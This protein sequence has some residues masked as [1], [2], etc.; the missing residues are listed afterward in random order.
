VAVDASDNLYVS[1]YAD[2]RVLRYDT[3]L[4]TDTTA[5]AVL[6]QLD[7]THVAENLTDAQGL[8]S[9]ESVAIDKSVTPN[10][11]YVS[12]S[13]NNRVLGWADAASFSNAAPADLV[14]GQPDFLSYLCNGIN[15]TASASTLCDPEGVAVDGSGNLYIADT[16]NQRV[17]EYANP[18][19]AC[20]NNFP[21]VGGA[22]NLVLGQGNSF[23]SNTCDFDTGGGFTDP[24]SAIDLCYPTGV[25]V[26]G[27]GNLYV[28]DSSNSRVVEYN[29]PLST[30]AAAS[31]VFGQGGSFTSKACDFDAGSPFNPPSAVDL[32]YP[33]GVAVDGLGNLYVADINNQRVLEYNTPLNPSSGESSAGDATADTVFGQGGSFT[34]KKCNLGGRSANSL[35][36][37]TAVAADNAGNVYIEDGTNSRVLEYNTPLTSGT[38]AEQVFG[39][40]GSFTSSEC[41]GVSASSLTSPSG[42]AADAAGNLYVVDSGDN[43]VL[44]YDQ[45][46]AGPTPTVSPTPTFTPTSTGVV[47]PTA[48]ATPTTTPTAT[49]TNTSTATA[50]ATPTPTPIPVKLSI[51]P[52]AI[53]FG[54]KTAVGRTSKPRAVTIKNSSKKG[55]GLNVTV[56]METASPS[57]FVI[58]SSCAKALAPGKSCKA[59]VTF[60]PIDTMPQT[61]S[62]KIFDN[63]SGSPQIVGLSGTGKTARKK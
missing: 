29:S 40:C 12:D 19:T 24:A 60:K 31:E 33:T 47:T 14:I 58:K 28:S 55:S 3:P 17:L 56:A 25:A 49:A 32:C 27:G 13:V 62:L 1:D 38:T 48:T 11:V 30:G 4:T 22:A 10:R 8:Y 53:S 50:S 21:C 51:S 54:S 5:D 18:F 35:C 26:D 15:D 44:E 20:G 45:P 39:T 63:A 7:F 34:S 61:G 57:V 23:T 37:P 6:G 16:D 41:T 36:G 2:N 59:S 9:P 42:V 43:R 46:L 52:G